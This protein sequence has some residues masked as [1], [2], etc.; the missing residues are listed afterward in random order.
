MKKG[1]SA[2]LSNQTGCK[3]WFEIIEIRDMK[4][5]KDPPHKCSEC[6]NEEMIGLEIIG[7]HK[8][9]LFWECLLCQNKHLRFSKA[10][11]KKLLSKLDLVTINIDDFI[12]IQDKEPN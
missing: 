11:T 7:A 3:D 1:R 2:L 8:D 5:Y 9:F 4:V 10:Y 12:D 6:E